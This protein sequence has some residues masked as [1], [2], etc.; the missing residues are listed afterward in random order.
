MNMDQNKDREQLRE[1][2]YRQSRTIVVLG[3]IIFLLLISVMVLSFCGRTFPSESGGVCGVKD[4]PAVRVGPIITN[5]TIRGQK[6]FKQNCATCH[7]DFSSET[8]TGPGLKGIFDRMNEDY[9]IKYT[10]NNE[11]VKKSGD[12][13]A[14]MLTA[15]YDSLSMNVFEGTLSEDDVREIIKFLKVPMRTIVN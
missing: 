2:V 9:F 12:A 6:L 11:K 8:I 4:L 14:N 13:Y 1:L 7:H 5:E 15:K 3:V 10:I